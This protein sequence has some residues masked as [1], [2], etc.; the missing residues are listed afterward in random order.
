MTTGWG[1]EAQRVNAQGSQGSEGSALYRVTSVGSRAGKS[2]MRESEM[3]RSEWV[4][5]KGEDIGGESVAT[6]WWS[7]DKGVD[8]GLG[9]ARWRQVW[10]W[11]GFYLAGNSEVGDSEVYDVFRVKV[12]CI[13]R[14]Q[15]VER[16]GGNGKPPPNSSDGTM[17]H[18]ASNG[19]LQATRSDR[20]D[21][22]ETMGDGREASEGMKGGLGQGVRGMSFGGIPQVSRVR[23]GGDD[24]ERRWK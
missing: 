23:Q 20:V 17:A 19:V 2:E 6:G 24:Y 15:G 8:D 21:R 22:R 4:R 11:C 9:V 7:V 10:R 1:R 13:V 18:T 14:E 3:K 16:D 12:E 5:R